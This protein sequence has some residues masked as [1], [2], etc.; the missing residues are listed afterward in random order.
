[1][2][3]TVDNRE[4]PDCANR[5]MGAVLSENGSVMISVLGKCMR[6]MGCR[7]I[8]VIKTFAD[9]QLKALWNTGKSRIDARLHVRILRRLE[10]LNRATALEDLNV[11]GMN[12]HGLHGYRAK[13]YTVHVNG[14]WCITFEFRDVDAYAVKFEQYH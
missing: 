14:P 10:Y 2:R 5:A 11:P 6:L 4:P 12:F 7:S 3:Q 8:E 9:K 13:R 1:M